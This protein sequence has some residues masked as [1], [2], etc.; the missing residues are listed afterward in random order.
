[1]QTHRVDSK[2]PFRERRAGTWGSGVIPKKGDLVRLRASV[3]PGDGAG[4]FRKEAAGPPSQAGAREDDF[5]EMEKVTVYP[6]HP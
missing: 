1:M 2:E 3:G 4:D 6:R 5:P